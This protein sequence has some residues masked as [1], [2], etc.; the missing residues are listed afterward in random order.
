MNKIGFRLE[1]LTRYEF[2]EARGKGNF[3]TAIIPTGSIEQHL[4]HLAMNQDI[5]S[6]TYVAEKVA[7]QL[8][9]EVI[10]AV[11]IT[12]GISEHHME[13]PGT[14]TAKP[15]SW[16]TTLFDCVESLVRAG[17][18]NIMILNGHGGNVIPVESS[19]EQ[20]KMFF[21]NSTKSG[22]TRS[23]DLRFHSY[24]DFITKETV[25][26]HLASGLYPGHAGEFETSI[27]MHIEPE[28]VRLDLMCEQ[29]D[30]SLSQSTSEKGRLLIET[31]VTG[32]I[33]IVNEMMKR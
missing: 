28:N 31:A 15:G 25:T 27:M 16:L 9:P 30:S 12:V 3:R 4:E 14:L 20:W 24:W 32:A 5:R 29:N 17:V 13:H 7:S 10:V 2:R 1:K 23:L 22:D 11:P 26:D 8:F 18:E 21:K 19:I 6:S 33:E